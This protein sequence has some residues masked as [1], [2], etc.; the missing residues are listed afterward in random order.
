M[1]SQCC[2]TKRVTTPFHAKT[3]IR[4]FNNM[5]DHSAP[6]PYARRESLTKG[7][8]IFKARRLMSSTV[9]IE[10]PPG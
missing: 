7:F 1:L 4:T 10:A 9:F 5:R 6:I 3:Y 8:L 2:G